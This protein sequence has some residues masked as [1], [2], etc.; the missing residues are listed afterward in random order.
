MNQCTNASSEESTAGEKT[1]TL[2][3]TYAHSHSHTDHTDKGKGKGK[4]LTS[5]TRQRLKTW[6]HP[7]TPCPHPHT[8]RPEVVT[9]TNQQTMRQTEDGQKERGE[10]STTDP[11]KGVER[12]IEVPEGCR[13]SEGEHF[14]N[15]PPT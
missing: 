4:E 7:L 8:R 6:P 2:T 11:E 10:P 15:T 13:E 5:T 3:H 14:T 9:Y 12:E 1:H